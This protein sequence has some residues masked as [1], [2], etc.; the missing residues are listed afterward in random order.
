LA[1]G[2]RISPRRLVLAALMGALLVVGK[3]VMSGLPNIEPVSFLVLLY[4]LEFPRETPWAISVFLL[5][6]GVLYGFGLWWAMY[7]YVWFVLMALVRLCKRCDSAL[8]WALLLGLFGL[9]FGAL[10]APVYVIMQDLAF[11]F[12]WW[13]AGLSFDVSHAAGNFVITLVLYRPMRRA[14]QTVK[15]QLGWT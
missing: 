4:A 8:L 5:L 10:C 7:I 9:C 13:L 12:T 3:Q 2:I 14:L 1:K 15:R 11:A 6:Q